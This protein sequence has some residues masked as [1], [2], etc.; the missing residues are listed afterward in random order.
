MCN[1]I[2]TFYSKD[3]SDLE[4]HEQRLGELFEDI[5]EMSF[6]SF[7]NKILTNVE[8]QILAWHGGR[9]E[10]IPVQARKLIQHGYM[11]GGFIVRDDMP[12]F[13]LLRSSDPQV[14]KRIPGQ[15]LNRD[16][17]ALAEFFK[18]YESDFYACKSVDDLICLQTQLVTELYEQSMTSIRLTCEFGG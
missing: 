17:E 16:Y 5:E 6:D 9:S 11:L 3:L 7:C 13:V 18:R 15:E 12:L 4:L 1:K 2:R 14:K 8:S 10:I